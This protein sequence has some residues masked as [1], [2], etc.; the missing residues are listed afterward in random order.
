MFWIGLVFVLGSLSLHLEKYE[1]KIEDYCASARQ[2]LLE[3]HLANSTEADAAIR[4]MLRRVSTLYS[5]RRRREEKTEFVLE[6][7]GY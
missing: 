3:E 1:N 5:S 7:N 2:E 4:A 6:S